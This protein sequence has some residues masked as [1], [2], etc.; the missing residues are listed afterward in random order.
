M[1]RCIEKQQET[2]SSSYRFY[3]HLGTTS[4]Q[5]QVVQMEAVDKFVECTNASTKNEQHIL[6]IKSYALRR[7]LAKDVAT[8]YRE[9][10]NIYTE[11]KKNSDVFIIKRW[12]KRNNGAS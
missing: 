10:A 12:A 1:K 4:Q 2:R 8:K 3:T 11:F 6:S 5:E 7:Q 9:S